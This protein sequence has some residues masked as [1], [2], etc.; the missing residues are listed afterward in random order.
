MGSADQLFRVR[1]SALLK[2][3]EEGVISFKRA[4]AK[5]HLSLAALEAAFPRR[6]CIS[7]RHRV[8]LPKSLG[9]KRS[10]IVGGEFARDNGDSIQLNT[11]CRET[12]PMRR[13]RRSIR[14]AR[15]NRWRRA[16]G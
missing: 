14:L 4:A 11:D 2:A 10:D 8:L 5:F 16:R 12:R 15:R 7:N 1:A 9:L 13:R 6:I 3:A